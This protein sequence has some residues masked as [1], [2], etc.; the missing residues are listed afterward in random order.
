MAYIALKD[1]PYY[2]FGFLVLAILYIIY[3]QT[4]FRIAFLTVMLKQWH[5]F[6]RSKATSLSKHRDHRNFSG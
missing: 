4:L 2:L 3:S 1:Y 5:T 6:S